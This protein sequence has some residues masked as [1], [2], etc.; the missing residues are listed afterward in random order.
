[1]SAAKKET[2]PVPVP[3]RSQEMIQETLAKLLNTAG[4]SN[5]YGKPIKHGDTT[6]IPAAEVIALA[7]F[8]VGSGYGIG[9]EAPE[10]VSGMGGGEGG[11][12]GGRTFSRPVAV[13][14][15]SEEGVR[16]EPVYDRSKILMTAIT[17][18]G[19]FLAMMIRM[20]RPRRGLRRIKT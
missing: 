9:S 15:A 2:S 4:A 12:G 18:G 1:M 19:F 5:V 20:M 6:I 16:V 7:G 14:I 11:G 10:D 3:G 13:I 17:A 8:G